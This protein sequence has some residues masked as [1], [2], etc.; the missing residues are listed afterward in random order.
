MALPQRDISKSI[1]VNATNRE[2]NLKNI[3]CYGYAKRRDVF[4]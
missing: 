3:T 1:Y 2:K 4:A